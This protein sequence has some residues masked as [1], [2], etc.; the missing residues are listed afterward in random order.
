MFVRLGC[1]GSIQLWG[2][3]V[4]SS[5]VPSFIVNERTKGT[6]VTPQGPK[7]ERVA[8]HVSVTERMISIQEKKETK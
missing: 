4:P 6:T 7:E 2:H 3:I 8:A 1:A 5:K